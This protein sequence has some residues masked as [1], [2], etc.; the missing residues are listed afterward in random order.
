MYSRFIPQQKKLITHTYSHISSNSLACMH[1][2]SL[3]EL[4]GKRK[5]KTPLN[6]AQLDQQ[7]YHPPNSLKIFGFD[8]SLSSSHDESQSSPNTSTACSNSSTRKYECQYCCREF[9][10]SQALGGHQNAHKKERQQLKRAQLLL[11]TG[12]S[13]N[14]AVSRILSFGPVGPTSLQQPNGLPSVVIPAA[15]FGP[16]RYGAWLYAPRERVG[17]NAGVGRVRCAAG[18]GETRMAATTSYCEIG[19][20]NGLDDGIGLDLHLSLA[21][22]GP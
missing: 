10:N 17:V 19:S 5:K 14:V 13:Q 9:A 3:L 15:A 7:H 1:I 18:V 12:S 11:A 4:T 2:I 21:P 16:H 22:A 6:M 8:F 20:G